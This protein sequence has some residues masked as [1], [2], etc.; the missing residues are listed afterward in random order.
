MAIT[1]HIECI[2]DDYR[3][4]AG[5]FFT[6][7]NEADRKMVKSIQQNVRDGNLWAWCAVTVTAECNGF[8]GESTCLGACSYESKA[9]FEA[10]D[11]YKDL[12]EEALNELQVK[13]AEATEAAREVYL[14]CNPIARVTPGFELTATRDK[15][16][17]VTLTFASAHPLYGEQSILLQHD[18]DVETFLASLSADDRK[19]INDNWDTVITVK[20]F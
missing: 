17:C 10:S 11:Y 1:Y 15:S 16:G 8:T 18:V 5:S 12:C 14:E 13:L 9:D 4:I 3:S 7:D 19:S 6:G 2:Q 20:S